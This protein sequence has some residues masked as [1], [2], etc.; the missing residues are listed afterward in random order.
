VTVSPDQ[1]LF[2][3]NLICMNADVLPEF[4]KQADEDFFA[5]RYSIGLWFWEVSRF[6][7]YW[8][9]SFSLVEEVW[10][11]TAHVA[12]ALAPLATVPVTTVRIPVQPPQTAP[13]SRAALGLPDDQFV[14]LFS[15]DY[16]SVFRRKNPLAV[17]EAFRRS[18]SPGEGAKLILKCI[19]SERDAD[20]HARLCSSVAEHPDI[21]IVDRYLSPPENN[22]LTALCDCYVSLHRA[23]GLG[24]VMAEA[25]A[26]GKP[27]IATGY[28]GNLDFMT[29]SNSLLVRH[30]LVPVGPAAGPYPEEGEWADPD[31]EHASVLMREVFDD[32]EAARELGAQAAEDIR[33]THSREA[34]GEILRSRLEE[35]WSTART[36]RPAESEQEAPITLSALVPRMKQPPSPGD[37]PVRG[38]P[39]KLA[40]NVMLRLMRPFTAY[41]ET[42]NREVL[43]VL[44]GLRT[45]SAPL[46]L[47]TLDDQAAHVRLLRE[48]RGYEE[49]KALPSFVDFH[50]STIDQ[51]KLDLTALGERVGAPL[52][53]TE[54]TVYL[55]LSQLRTRHAAIRAQR[56]EP[57]VTPD[58]SSFELRVFSQNGEDGVLAEVLRRVGAPTRF[59]VEFGAEYG[60][61]GNCVYLADV[62]RWH[63]LF[64]EPTEEAYRMLERKYA[65]E[66]G[67][68][69]IQ[70]AVTPENIEQF[71]TQGEVPPEPDVLSID[72]DG[73][74]YWV[75]EAIE[76]YRPRVVVIEYNSA[77]DPR[78][79]LVEP[80]QP[81]RV[82]EGTEYFGASLG[83]LRTLGDRKGYRLVHTELSGCNAFFV[84]DDLG[85]EA[86]LEPT[87]VAVRGAPNYYQSGYRHPPA[88]PGRRYLDLDTNEQVDGAE[89]HPPRRS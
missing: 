54:R 42:V 79:R 70:A 12:E 45:G 85:G 9:D 22:T 3:V 52:Q 41:Q 75:W 20:N 25:M 66:S 58:L 31:I 53:L 24:L 29:D 51:I 32:P 64:L 60:R 69:T 43:S 30:R 18:F 23:E 73:Q 71:F 33:R 81:G 44:E 38:S 15:F 76:S 84:R 28:S 80:K 74:D 11:P 49:L 37:Q 57:P 67:V 26:L 16:L 5:G 89:A 21:E 1:A 48:L 13:L 50:G 56:G 47:G 72:I 6:P 65:M 4:A 78:R 55:A 40:R 59:F 17:V 36:R 82:W 2:A 83:A 35:I 88:V 14:F 63:G 68:R 27:V 10:A 87:E 61:E 77:L 19:N 39:R 86:F 62:A 8:Q 7:E 46:G 34:A